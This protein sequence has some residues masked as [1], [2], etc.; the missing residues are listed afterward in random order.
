MTPGRAVVYL[1]LGSNLGDRSEHLRIALRLLAGV[2]TVRAVAPWYATAPLYVTDQPEFLNTAC[3][4]DTDLAPDQLLERL[5]GI[6]RQVGRTP[7]R[8]YGERVLDID[9]LLFDDLVLETPE[10]TI[11]HPRLAERAFALAPLADLAPAVVHPLLHRT[12]AELWR[13]VPGRN[14]VRKL[15]EG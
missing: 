15:P 11:P 4:L 12:V 13:D 6:E 7:G 3:L 1:G 10:L 9:I 2:G 14:G 5:Q 8:R